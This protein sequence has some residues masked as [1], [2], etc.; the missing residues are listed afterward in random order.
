MTNHVLIVDDDP[1]IRDLVAYKLR[2][3]SYVV[4]VAGDGEAALQLIAEQHPDLVLLDIMMPGMSG[5]EVL[6]HIRRA[7][8]GD[9]QLCVAL[10][11]AKAQESDLERGFA[12]GADDY[13][14]KPFSP[15]ELAS[16]VKAM[17]ARATR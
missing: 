4:S 12:L 2:H 16:R 13:I 9:A 10:L 1:D 11:T 6:E 17:L 14:V 15:L 8:N 7:D 3:E 5:L